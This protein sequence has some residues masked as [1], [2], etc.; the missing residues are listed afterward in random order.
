MRLKKFTAAA[1]CAALAVGLLA[2]PVS[3]LEKGAYTA[4]CNTYYRNPD[5]GAIDDGGSK[6]ES[7]GEGM[8]LPLYMKAL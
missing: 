3:A 7:L 8:C 1:L 5:T 4:P 6:D 2:L